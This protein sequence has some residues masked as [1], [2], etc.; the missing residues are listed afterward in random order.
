MDFDVG[1]TQYNRYK[2]DDGMKVIPIINPSDILII[3]LKIKLNKLF[4]Y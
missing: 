1:F 4:F 3:N 2:I